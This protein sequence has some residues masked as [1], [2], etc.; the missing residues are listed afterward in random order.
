MAPAPLLLLLPVLGVVRL[1]GAGLPESV[2]GPSTRREA[3]WTCT[4]STSARTLGRPGGREPSAEPRILWPMP[5]AAPRAAGPEPLP[6]PRGHVS[7]AEISLQFPRG[8]DQSLETGTGSKQP[9]A[10]EAESW[11]EATFG[12]LPCIFLTLATSN[13]A[14]KEAGTAYCHLEA[15]RVF[16]FSLCSWPMVLFSRLVWQISATQKSAALFTLSAGAGL[17]DSSSQNGKESS[18][19]MGQEI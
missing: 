6:R 1:A 9:R 17:Q 7:G 8:P 14:G 2:I 13:R 10:I 5:G 19:R 18:K 12:P 3:M 4:G 11:R 15:S 16:R